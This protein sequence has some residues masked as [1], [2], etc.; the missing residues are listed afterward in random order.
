[1]RKARPSK[2]F[3]Y[4]DGPRNE[5]DL[6]GI[7]ACRTIVEQIDWECEV[8]RFTINYHRQ[9]RSKGSIQSIL[10][11]IPG[12]G[13]K[14]RKELI[15][16]FGSVKK[17]KEASTEELNKILTEIGRDGNNKIQRYKGSIS[18]CTHFTKAVE[19]ILNKRNNAEQ[20]QSPKHGQDK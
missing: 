11:N 17:I 19:D 6:K 12:I 20:Q 7:Q 4:Q 16:T 14:R 3:L 10:D 13:G 9:I 18:E 5:K 1:M 15:K 2:L 8:H